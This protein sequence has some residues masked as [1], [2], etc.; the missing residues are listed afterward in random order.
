M[1]SRK[2]LFLQVIGIVVLVFLLL[3]IGD[4]ARDWWEMRKL[5]K[6]V[7]NIEEFEKEEL[8]RMMADTVGGS[9]PQETLQ[10]YIEAVEVGDFELASMYFVEDEREKELKSFG[11]VSKEDLDNYVELLR[12]VFAS[13]GDYFNNGK[14]FSVEIPVY[15]RMEFYPNGVWKIL[16][17]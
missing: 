5:D 16:E 15:V 2:K 17:I 9:T 8:A 1:G 7:E 13:G 12:A 10:M 6:V 4:T 3:V 14:S 11:G